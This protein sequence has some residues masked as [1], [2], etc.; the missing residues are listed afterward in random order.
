[1]SADV[2][3]RDRIEMRQVLLDRGLPPSDLSGAGTGSRSTPLR[4]IEGSV[5]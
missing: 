1:L 3:V 4:D 2:S 5:H